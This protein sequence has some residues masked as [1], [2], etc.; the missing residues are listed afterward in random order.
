MR[1][2]RDLSGIAKNLDFKSEEEMLTWFYLKE[3]MSIGKISRA[4][5]VPATTLNERLTRLKIH[6]RS[7]RNLK[8]SDIPGTIRSASDQ[9]GVPRSTLWRRRKVVTELDEDS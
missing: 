2:L 8:G 1:K 4:I 7:K 6:K 3:G 5:G 9:T